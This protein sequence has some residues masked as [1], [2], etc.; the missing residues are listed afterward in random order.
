M[1]KLLLLLGIIGILTFLNQ[2]QAA[3]IVDTGSGP[4]ETEGWV[5]D[6]DNHQSLAAKFS[7]TQGYALTDIYGWMGLAGPSGT[8]KISI[9]GDA[10]VIPSTS[11]LYSQDLSLTNPAV[12]WYGLSG[13]NWNLASGNYW[14]VF[15]PGSSQLEAFMPSPS[16][17]PLLNEAFYLPGAGVWQQ[18]NIMDLGI[19]IL[20]NPTATPEPATM[21]LLGLGLLGLMGF[22]RKKL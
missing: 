20:G 11:I 12:N 18:N 7:L 9:Y 14:L 22:K 17:S 19:R 13:L 2:A 6:G 10:G 5:I 21:S 16:A 4:I 1:K 15:E 3:I 8:A